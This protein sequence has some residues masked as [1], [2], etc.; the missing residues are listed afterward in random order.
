MAKKG[1]VSATHLL[2]DIPIGKD[3]KMESR[4]EAHHLKGEFEKIGR[5]LGIKTKVIITDGSQPIGNGIGPALEARDVLW[6]LKGDKRAPQDLR[7]KALKMC[8]ILLE[9]TGKARKGQGLK[10]A[11]D[12]LESGKAYRKFVQIVKSQGAKTK[13]LNNIKLGRYSFDYKSPKNG[14][15]KHIS[16]KD[17]AKI[18]RIAGCPDDKEAGIYLYRHKGDKVRKGEKLF[19]IYADTKDKLKYAKEMLKAADGFVVG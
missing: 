16:N 9:M 19:T 13:N 4:K 11:T 17:M 2:V 5:G 18:A 7:K 1:S 15:V 8:G 6:V 14:A 12:I 10:M 3:S